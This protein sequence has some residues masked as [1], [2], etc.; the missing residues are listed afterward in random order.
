MSDVLV[1]LYVLC[2]RVCVCV[3][4][5]VCVHVCVCMCVCVYVHMQVCSYSTVHGMASY[6]GGQVTKPKRS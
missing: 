3:C 4:A 5:C 6:K 1:C 2:V